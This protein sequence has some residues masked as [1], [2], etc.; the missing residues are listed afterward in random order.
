MKDPAAFPKEK[1]FFAV[2]VGIHPGIYD[3]LEEAQM[4]GYPH[5]LGKVFYTIEGAKFW[6]EHE[7][8]PISTGTPKKFFD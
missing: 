1:K 2:K 3:N 6:L 7:D 5:C 8:E 4:K